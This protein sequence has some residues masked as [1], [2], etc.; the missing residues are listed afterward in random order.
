[1]W[2]GCGL[3]FIVLLSLRLPSITIP[4]ILN[5]IRLLNEVIV[6]H[7]T[8]VISAHSLPFCCQPPFTKY[9]YI[10]HGQHLWCT[11]SP[12]KANPTDRER[13]K[14]VI[15]QWEKYKSSGL[16]LFGLW[17]LV[18]EPNKTSRRTSEG[19]GCGDLICHWCSPLLV[20]LPLK[21]FRLLLAEGRVV[22]R[23]KSSGI[24]RS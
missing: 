11:L 7:H 24:I 23:C 2:P 10:W 17:K 13:G 16:E 21:G 9:I 8:F 20:Q 15:K 1:M 14:R 22:D 12:T 5:K 18:A 19:G 4:S 3:E 6:C